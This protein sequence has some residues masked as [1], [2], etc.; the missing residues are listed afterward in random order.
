M[1]DTPSVEFSLLERELNENIK[2]RCSQR[3]EETRK[4]VQQPYHRRRP[5]P[6]GD[7]REQC[8]CSEKTV[9][10]IISCGGA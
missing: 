7:M 1:T 3:T 9:C 4:P 5:S 6:G 10:V 2:E 8:R